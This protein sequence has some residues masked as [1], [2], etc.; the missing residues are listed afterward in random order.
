MLYKTIS[1]AVL[2]PVFSVKKWK[3]QF[4]GSFDYAQD[5]G[6]RPPLTPSR[7]KIGISVPLPNRGR[8]VY[9]RNDRGDPQATPNIFLWYNTHIMLTNPK[10]PT[11]LKKA[12]YLFLSVILGLLLSF[13]AHTAIEMSYLYGSEKFGYSV[14]YYNNCFLPPVLQIAILLGGI[15]GGFLL[16]RWWWQKVYVE[17]VWVNKIKREI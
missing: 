7:C 16:G 9:P 14:S 15:V 12:V 8:K 11:K 1:S 10:N 4:T 6:R 2:P 17:R 5:D 3:K 13:L